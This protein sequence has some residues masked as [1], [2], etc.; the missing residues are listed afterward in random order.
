MWTEFEDRYSGG[1]LKTKWE[2]IFIEAPLSEAAGIFEEKLDAYPYGEACE[3]C[4][5]DFHIETHAEAPD[6]TKAIGPV[7]VLRAP[8]F[9]MPGLAPPA[10]RRL[11]LHRQHHPPRPHGLVVQ[12]GA[13][14]RGRGL[15]SRRRP[16]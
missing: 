10:R 16:P 4:G 2:T 1:H 3:C 12:G 7:L 6:F 5:S 13:R 8:D 9:A 11:V 14:L 15:V